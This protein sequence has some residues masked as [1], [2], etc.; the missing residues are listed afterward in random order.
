MASER[1]AVSDP[2]AV[3]DVGRGALVDGSR[4]LVEPE[5]I[6]AA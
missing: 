3:P 2:Q 4:E 1:A 5:L 6:A